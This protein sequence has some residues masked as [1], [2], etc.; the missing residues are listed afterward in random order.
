MGIPGVRHTD[1]LT[2]IEDKGKVQKVYR[3]NTESSRVIYY[4]GSTHQSLED[5]RVLQSSITID[6]PNNDP[7]LSR[8]G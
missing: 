3:R 6:F 5:S 4:S 7:E 1:S 8:K 2:V